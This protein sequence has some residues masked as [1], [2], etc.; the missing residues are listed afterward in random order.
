MADANRST[1]IDRDDAPKDAPPGT[2]QTGKK[3]GD[4]RGDPQQQKRNREQMNEGV[5]D[6]HRTETMREQKRG[7][8]P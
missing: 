3:P 7:T 1:H 5:G 6:D 2:P 4:A 8:F